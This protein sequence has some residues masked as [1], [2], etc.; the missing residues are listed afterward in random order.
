MIG[1][2][3]YSTEGSFM[4]SRWAL[5]WTRNSLVEIFDAAEVNATIFQGRSGNS[6]QDAKAGSVSYGRLHATEN[7]V[8]IGAE[9]LKQTLKT[10]FKIATVFSASKQ[11]A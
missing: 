6:V 1:N 3:E 7:G 5:H 8:F 10:F 2:S 4:S 11:G 9:F